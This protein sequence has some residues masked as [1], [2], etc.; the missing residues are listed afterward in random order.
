M[1]YAML[2]TMPFDSQVD[3]FVSFVTR[4]IEIKTLKLHDK[5]QK[6]DEISLDEIKI[7]KRHQEMLDLMKLYLPTK[8]HAYMMIIGLIITKKQFTTICK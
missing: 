2:N 4:R 3:P 7:T 8:F 1:I 5:T 6:F